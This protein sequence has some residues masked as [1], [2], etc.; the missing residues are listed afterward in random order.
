MNNIVILR[1]SAITDVAIAAPLVRAYASENPNITFTVVSD[2][3]M[4]PLF[5]SGKNLHFCPLSLDEKPSI[6]SL[7]KAVHTVRSLSPTCIV[8]LQNSFAT[9]LMNLS[10]TFHNIPTY[11]AKSPSFDRKNYSKTSIP[12]IKLYEEALVEA[13]L[14]NLHLSSE[15]HPLCKEL[16]NKYEFHRI[17]VAPFA[18]HPGKSWPVKSMEKV[19]EELCKNPNN[20]VY[21]FGNQKKEAT[22]L[23]QWEN[24]YKDCESIAGKYTLAE[25]L[26]L[27]RSLDVM[28]TMD[29]ANM[30]FA[31]YVNTPVISIWG[32]THPKV[33]FYGWGQSGDNVVSVDMDCR[34]CSMFGDKKCERFDYACL[35]RV[36]PEMVLA[37]IDNFFHPSKMNDND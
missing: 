34:P 24:K 7:A 29:S 21:L 14:F 31:S 18:K 10:F 33:G 35:A 19:V 27:I 16:N 28:V 37:K 23:R 5:K 12:L 6:D 25:E 15:N 30:H 20:K 22:I 32:A 13:G 3:F 26:E 9:R 2:P 17:G 4:Q 1:F 11:T 8:D 36:T